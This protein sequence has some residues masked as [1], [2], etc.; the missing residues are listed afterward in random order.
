MWP[1]RGE[2]P[3]RRPGSLTRCGGEVCEEPLVQVDPTQGRILSPLSRPV[4]TKTPTAPDSGWPAVSPADG[5]S[6]AIGEVPTLYRLR[7]L[8]E[9]CCYGLLVA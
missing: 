3:L 2:Q 6:G 5:L 4:T 7:R 9:A 8:Q 1:G